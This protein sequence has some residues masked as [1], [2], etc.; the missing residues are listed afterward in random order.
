MGKLAKSRA[1]PVTKAADDSSKP[2]LSQPEVDYLAR[3]FYSDSTILFT[4]LG[5]TIFVNNL[6]PLGFR[7][8]TYLNENYTEFQVAVWWQL[9]ISTA[10]YWIWASF[11]FVLDVFG[12]PRSLRRYKIQ[13]TKHI[14][15]AEYGSI[16]LIVIRNQIFV[17]IPLSIAFFYA[18]KW[19]GSPQRAEDLPSAFGSVGAYFVGMLCIEAG[20]WTERRS[21]K[22]WRCLNRL[23]R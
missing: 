21:F 5:T 3:N 19:R 20:G 2:E 8:W 17:N 22:Q 18:S 4:V 6:T 12:W 14:G 9:A 16:A 7:F 11:F 13:P 23:V 10:V 15:L 1:A